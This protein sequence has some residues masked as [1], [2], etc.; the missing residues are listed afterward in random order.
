M[1][2]IFG[3]ALLDFYNGNYTEDLI[4][5][6]QISDEDELPLPYLFRSYKDMPA[7]E[8]KAMQRKYFRCRLWFWF[9]QLISTRKRI[10]SK[11]N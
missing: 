5:S 6:T 9:A 1:K 10:K 2:D 8:Q 11:S 3:K 7:L 4:T